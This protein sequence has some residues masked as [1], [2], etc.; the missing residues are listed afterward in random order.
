MASTSV[1]KVHQQD[2]FNLPKL[3]KEE[4]TSFGYDDRWNVGMTPDGK[5]I[6]DMSDWEARD[7]EDML[8]KG[9]KAQQLSRV[10]TLPLLSAEYT[11][12]PADDDNGQ[13][14]WLKSY[15]ETSP[16]SGG[17]QTPLRQ[18]VSMATSAFYYRRA[19]F[20]KVFTRGRGKFEGKV[21]YSDVAWRPQTTCRL[22][23]DPATGRFK[24]FEQDPLYFGN[25]KTLRLQPIDIPADRSFV[26]THGTHRDP[27]NGVSDLEVAYWSWKT[28]Q[29]V[30]MLWMQFLEGTSLP[31]VVVKSQD[32]QT[33]SQVAS[34]VAKMKA[35]GVL[36]VGVPGGPD[37]VG[38]ETLDLSGKGAEQFKAALDWLDQAATQSVLA[39]FL[40]LTSN[41]ANGAGSYALSDNASSFFLQSL[42]AKAR[43]LEDQVRHQLFA[44]LIR[45]NF[46]KDASVPRL[47]FEPLNALDKDTAVSLLRASM[48]L[49]PDSPVPS[50]FV[51]SLAEQVTEYLGMDSTDTK[52]NFEKAYAEAAKK[53]DDRDKTAQQVAG[54]QGATKAAQNMM[55]RGTPKGA[56]AGKGAK[57]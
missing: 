16:L 23:R 42:E 57:R 11:I 35:S 51:S 45:H 2:G 13:A 30:L 48:T 27:M 33:A 28:A 41:A 18:I 20:E 7:L 39:G 37:S 56:G 21:V 44:P 10:L 50:E 17:C 46:G 24:G 12:E 53:A 34:E 52:E 4:G 32:E 15:W 1:Q 5:N 22:M 38:I 54:M 29:K 14:K 49:T 40:D 8:R 3:N 43:E 25:V 9:Y 6:V 19:Y 31:K 26:Y 55:A 47:K 36:P